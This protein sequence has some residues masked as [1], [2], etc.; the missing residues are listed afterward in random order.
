MIQSL[1]GTDGAV[2]NR[3]KD[4][5]GNTCE[6]GERV[7]LC[8]VP[9]GSEGSVQYKVELTGTPSSLARV[10]VTVWGDLRDYDDAEEIVEWLK[11]TVKEL[12]KQGIGIR[13]GAFHIEVE[14]QKDVYLLW[15][16][17]QEWFTYTIEKGN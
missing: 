2:I 9:Y 14:S 16:D 10:V 13:G 5:F 12:N 6:Y 7:D 8:D 15:G 4:V 3:I 17:R 1:I 11:G